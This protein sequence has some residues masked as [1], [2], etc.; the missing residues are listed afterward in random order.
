LLL[1]I[2]NLF[3]NSKNFRFDPYV[4]LNDLDLENVVQLHYVGYE[5][6]PIQLSDT[7]S[8]ETQ[9]EI[10]SLMAAVLERHIPKGVL[11]E[12]DERFE[13]HEEISKDLNTAKELLTRI[14][15]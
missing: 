7:H 9:P 3:I 12:R 14:K 2:T 8:K 15:A 5:D 6:S 1:D 13:A 11:L 4:F 10:F